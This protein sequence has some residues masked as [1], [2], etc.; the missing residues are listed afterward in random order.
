MREPMTAQRSNGS[1][2]PGVTAYVTCSRSSPPRPDRRGGRTDRL[3]SGAGRRACLP[4]AVLAALLLFVLAGCVPASAPRTLKVGLV[5]PFSGR[6]AALG[7]NMLVGAKLALK[8]WNDRG[9]AGGSYIE[10]VAQ[11]DRNDPELGAMQARKMALDP[12][13]VGVAGHPSRESAL[14]AAPIYRDAGLPAML[15]GPALEAEQA[16]GPPVLLMGPTQRDV[17]ERAVRFAVA[18]GAR[19]LAVIVRVED[20]GAARGVPPADASLAGMVATGARDAGLEVPAGGVIAVIPGLEDVLAFKLRD[21]RVD[22]VFYDGS[23]VEG[24]AVLS[25]M[26]SR[27]LSAIFL[28]GPGVGYPDFLKL[29]GQAAEGAYY[30]STGP[31]PAGLDTARPFVD[32]FRAA[33]GTDPWP[34]SLMAYQAMN[35]MLDTLHRGGSSGQPPSRAAL[36]QSLAAG[37]FEDLT[38]GRGHIYRVE[39]LSWPGS[40]VSVP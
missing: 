13:V 20:P 15:A 17:A 18:Q 8:D 35:G 7:Y 39:R 24:A 31:S 3:P 40:E 26:R 22:M 37:Q 16:G 23:Y 34:Q 19:R 32:A 25:A 36:R 29:A 12:Q 4:Y 5:A 1:A 14:A 11:D 27:G 10:L 33:A 21:L 2:R 38:G 28:G 9:G 6:D 30:F